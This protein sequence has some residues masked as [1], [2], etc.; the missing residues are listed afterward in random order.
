MSQISNSTAYKILQKNLIIL[1]KK[2]S[3][4]LLTFLQIVQL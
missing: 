1:R 3:Q 2:N 4:N